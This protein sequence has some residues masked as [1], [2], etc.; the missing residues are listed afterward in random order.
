MVRLN[1]NSQVVVQVNV[2]MNLGIWTDGRQ[3]DNREAEDPVTLVTAT[4]VC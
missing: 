4:E 1:E 3:Q 2:C